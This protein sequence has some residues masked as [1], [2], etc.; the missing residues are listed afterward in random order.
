MSDD[1]DDLRK[2]EAV[3][4][5]ILHPLDLSRTGIDFEVGSA[6]GAASVIAALRGTSLTTE[7]AR[8][9]SRKD[10]NDHTLTMKTAQTKKGRRKFTECTCGWVSPNSRSAHAAQDAARA[11]HP[12]A[13]CPTPQKRHYPDQR[14]AE[15]A[16]LDFWQNA[17][18]GKKELRRAYE[19]ECGKWHTTSKPESV[20][21]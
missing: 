14:S 3:L 2:A 5:E 7:I 4:D 15:L 12:Q 13:F 16:L 6:R 8:S 1:V 19:C 21:S 11:Q 10:G 17:P 20:A 9:K 18:L